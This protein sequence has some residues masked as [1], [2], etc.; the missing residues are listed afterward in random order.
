MKP[1]R[2]TARESV[3][4]QERKGPRVKRSLQ[5]M[6]RTRIHQKTMNC[7]TRQRL[8]SPFHKLVDIKHFLT[9]PVA[10]IHAYTRSAKP[11]AWKFNK[12]YQ[13]WIIKNA[14]SIDAVLTPVIH[15]LLVLMVLSQI[16]EKY[17][18][19]LKEY[20]SGCQGKAKDVRERLKQDCSHY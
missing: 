13:N 7:P 17:N 16:P 15:F 10:L 20:L 3:L 11:E 19:I 9:L 14:I 2:H 18:Y 4:R 12:A 1:L 6:I 8:V 5:M